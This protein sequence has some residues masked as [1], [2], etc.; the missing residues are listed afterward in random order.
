ML[1][2]DSILSV[3]KS[4]MCAFD[5][6]NVQP[7]RSKRILRDDFFIVELGLFRFSVLKLSHAFLA[8]VELDVQELYIAI[9]LCI[10]R[11]VHRYPF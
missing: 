6:V 4:L 2:H 9:N 7:C 1:L 5:G 11:E 8:L 10:N 3:V